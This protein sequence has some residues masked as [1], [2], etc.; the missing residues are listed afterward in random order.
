M[1][2][3]N[4]HETLANI[5]FSSIQIN[6]NAISSPHTDNNLEGYP[7]I[8]MGFGDFEGGRL[9]AEGCVPVS[10]SGEAVVF[11]G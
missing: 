3:T 9:K 6:H 2:E 5:K 10:I 11:D 8:A 4:K 7:S 1:E